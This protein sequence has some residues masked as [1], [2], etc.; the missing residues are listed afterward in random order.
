[1]KTRR[2][3]QRVIRKALDKHA[4]IAPPAVAHAAQVAFDAL[5][6]SLAVTIAKDLEKAKLLREGDE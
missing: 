5:K 1:V 4:V 6:P 2:E 3:A